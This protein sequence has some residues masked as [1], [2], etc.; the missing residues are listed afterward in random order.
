PAAPRVG[1]GGGWWGPPGRACPG[2][3]G[4]SARHQL[5][6]R[7]RLPFAAHAQDVLN[8]YAGDRLRPLT[9]AEHR[10]LPAMSR[11]INC[12]LC[13]LVVK[14][15]GGV[16]L[17]DLPTAYMRDYTQLPLAVADLEGGDPGTH[18]LHTPAAA[19]PVAVP[20]AD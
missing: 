14:R 18:A 13:A 16:R 19:R 15:V 11:C 1:A 9:L 7:F 17:A 20:L 2:W 10:Q 12:G 4:A 8:T 5:R 6:R 3:G